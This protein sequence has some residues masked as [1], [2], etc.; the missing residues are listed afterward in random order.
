MFPALPS[1]PKQGPPAD[2]NAKI[3]DDIAHILPVLVRKS[4]QGDWSVATDLDV[5]ALEV[6]DEADGIHSF[7]RVATTCSL[8]A[9]AAFMTRNQDKFRAAYFFA[10]PEDLVTEYALQVSA[11][12]ADGSSCP[13][14]N[15]IHRHVE[16]EE[17]KKEALFREIQQRH[18]F[19]YRIDKESMVTMKRLLTQSKCRD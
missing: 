12:P 8:V 11:V 3:F 5:A 2:G 7:Y 16:I 10:L 13:P 4:R 17:K 1:A 18:V 6:F 14:L 9:V 19:N 15:A